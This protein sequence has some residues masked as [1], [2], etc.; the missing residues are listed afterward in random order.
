M[1]QKLCND[2][3]TTSLGRQAGKNEKRIPLGGE[4]T[5]SRAQIIEIFF[6]TGS[7]MEDKRNPE[8]CPGWRRHARGCLL[9]LFNCFPLGA[10][11]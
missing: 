5:L 9:V 2:R 11:I 10:T 8:M 4:V 7:G 6:L 3:C 1:L